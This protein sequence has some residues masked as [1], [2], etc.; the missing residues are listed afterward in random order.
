MARK[1]TKK[2][3]LSMRTVSQTV[4]NKKKRSLV[5]PEKAVRL[6]IQS[7]VAK[8][9]KVRIYAQQVK[10]G[11]GGKVSIRDNTV[12]KKPDVPVLKAL[13]EK[14]PRSIIAR[15]EL[16]LALLSPFRFPLPNERTIGTVARYA[17]VFFVL[18]GAI[19]SMVNLDYINGD[20][21]TD[22]NARHKAQTINSTASGTVSTSSPAAYNTTPDA[23]ISIEGAS[24]LA[25]MA[26]IMVT[27]ANASEVK[28]IAQSNST[29]Q[30]ITLG[31]AF[32]VDSSTWRFY[33]D[34]RQYHDGEYQLRAVVKNQYGS[35]EHKDSTVYAV[36]NI[37]E[38]IE[39]VEV[40]AP[41]ETTAEGA[42]T[43]D[44]T[45]TDI[46]QVTD[47]T[48]TT[49]PAVEPSL[50]LRIGESSPLEGIVPLKVFAHDASEV[51]IYA[52]NTRMNALYYIGLAKLYS[53]DEW[54]VGWNTELVPDGEY[55]VQA[56]GKIA[57]TFLESGYVKRI[58]ENGADSTMFTAS[59]TVIAPASTTTA[60][61]PADTMLK[62]TIELT[63]S[64]SSPLSGFVDVRVRTSEVESVE[65]YAVPRSSLTP[66]FLGLGQKVSNMDWKYVWSTKQSPNGEYD[67]YARVKTSYGFTEGTRMKVSVFNEVAPIFTKAQETTID[68]LREAKDVLVVETDG[69]ADEVEGEGETYVPPKVVYIEPVST[70]VERVSADD[71]SKEEI[72][73]LLIEFRSALNGKINELARAIRN[74]DTEA[75]E[76]VKRD[77]EDIKKKVIADVSASGEKKGILDSIDTY[78]S[79]VAFE[80][81]E[82]TKQ[83]ET[84]LR[85]RVGDAIIVDSDKDGISDYDE[86]NLYRTNPFAADTDGD[87]YIDS[88]E[89]K[90][91]YNPHDARSE[92]LV[93]YE[94]PKE[95]G[96]VRE[97]LLVVHSITTLSDSTGEDASA[98]RK[99][100][101]K[102]F[103]SGKGLPNSFITL[104]IYS[105]P[106]VLTVKTDA[107][108]SWSYIFDKELE[109][110]EHEVYVGI[111]DNAGRVVAKSNPLPFVKTA[112]AFTEGGAVASAVNDAGGE[113][114]LLSERMML[115]V[116]S[117]A[118]VGLGL[119]L[120]LL[121]LHVRRRE[122]GNV[123]VQNA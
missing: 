47:T 19:F 118:V 90:L 121:G 67:L 25:D 117:M 17:G 108:G 82:L 88:V 104:Y 69:I 39:V 93:T 51:K 122:E 9:E 106:I 31:T 42:T 21:F 33:W 38:V 83:N 103:I 72:E 44:T 105:T 119:V 49:T 109:D 34:T 64:A 24:P 29:Q 43:T 102:A 76:K 86:I 58:V 7:N 6:T 116:A 60:P 23:R 11:K 79:Q 111:T 14:A 41:A 32:K 95:V 66:F 74:G 4:R 26:V 94:S 37:V 73:R 35:Y 63:L 3:L 56:K 27:V 61:V 8:N 50:S 36:D 115:L 96:I 101:P 98:E 81:E 54:R 120:I 55:R 20:T 99:A 100:S 91:G 12:K 70:F 22:G 59:S 15:S 65:L 113:P 45:P 57:G 77:I 13:K 62:P 89:I 2:P 48:P 92:A 10:E 97:D 52:R 1:V 18:V 53:G 71:D 75:L 80:L 16:Q 123:L 30:L 40:E 85:E 110:G 114:T 68:T 112:E 5:R 46:A 107:E 28:L 84:T 78:L 87:S